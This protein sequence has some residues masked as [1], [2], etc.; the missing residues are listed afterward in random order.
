MRAVAP[1]LIAAYLAM[2]QG[3]VAAA[4]FDDPPSSAFP[5]RFAETAAEI[6]AMPEADLKKFY[7][8]CSRASVRGRLGSGE[9]QLCS[10][11]YER[12]LQQSFGGDFRAFLA[13]RRGAMRRPEPERPNAT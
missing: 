1:L 4:D 2:A 5:E 13:W 9:I 12:L 8:R 3:A 11:G 6:A 10:I 7:L